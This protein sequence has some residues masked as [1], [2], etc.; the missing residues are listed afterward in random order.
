VVG[1]TSIISPNYSQ[2][3]LHLFNLDIDSKNSFSSKL[4]Q[5]S[6]FLIVQDQK[7]DYGIGR[8]RACFP[9]VLS[10]DRHEEGEDEEYG[11]GQGSQ[12][13]SEEGGNQ[14]S[15]G[16]EEEKPR[17]EGLAGEAAPGTAFFEIG[18]PARKDN[19]VLQF[20]CLAAFLGGL[21]A[22]F[23]RNDLPECA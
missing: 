7:Q 4:A 6:S 16:G 9:E 20:G 15:P 2:L 12:E 13:G 21:R 14:T 23:G 19:E 17:C 8:K 3:R 18:Q 10:E 22:G 5:I 1:S 11:R